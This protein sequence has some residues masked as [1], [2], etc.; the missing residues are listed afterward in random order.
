[1]LQLEARFKRREHLR[2]PGAWK[3]LSSEELSARARRKAFDKR[4]GNS[5]WHPTHA[6]PGAV[7][8]I[9][10]CRGCSK[11]VRTKIRCFDPSLVPNCT[12][13][14][15]APSPWKSPPLSITPW[16][17]TE[18]CHLGGSPPPEPGRIPNDPGQSSPMGFYLEQVPAA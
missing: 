16:G 1:M 12:R 17:T 5:G 8:V 6:N 11:P 4:L 13:D 10:G 15:A 3:G 9:F 18:D 2:N 14:V 7:R